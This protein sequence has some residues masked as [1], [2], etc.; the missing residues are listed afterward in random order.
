MG[1]AV[2]SDD[3][4]ASAR[5]GLGD[6]AAPRPLIHLSE[7]SVTVRPGQSTRLR[8]TVVNVGSVVET[9]SLT[10]LGEARAWCTLLP[11]EI[12]LFPGEEGSSTLVVRPPMSSQTIAGTYE[13]GVLATSQVRPSSRAASGA[14]LTV[15]SFISF[16]SQLARSS[17]DMRHST[18]TQLQI[19]N[20]GNVRIDCTV[21]ANDPSGVLRVRC[22]RTEVQLDP[23]ET[24][25][26]KLSISGPLHLFGRFKSRAIR[27]S[28]EVVRDDFTGRQPEGERPSLQVATVTQRPLLSLRL[29]LL[30]RLAVVLGV[31]ALVLTFVITRLL[32]YQTPAVSGAPNTPANFAATIV[33]NN[34][35]ALTWDA[36]SGAS[37]YDIYAVG[38]AGD[39]ASTATPAASPGGTP[40]PTGAAQGPP[41]AGQKATA[42]TPRTGASP[43]G[44]PASSN[45]P[46]VLPSPDDRK[47]ASPV[48]NNCTNVATVTGNTTRHVIQPL[49]ATPVSCY[50]IVA[51]AGNYQSLFSVQQCVNTRAA[52][53]AAASAAAAAAAASSQAATPCSPVKMQA[54]PLSS[55]AIA[56]LWSV[57]KTAPKKDTCSPTAVL[58]G[59]EIQRQILSGW[60]N[61][62]TQPAAADTALEAT[63][64][65]PATNY[66]FR[67]RAMTAT[68]SSEYTRTFCAKTKKAPVLVSPSPSVS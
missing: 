30:G 20:D 58:T 3:F 32:A 39:P 27:T 46:I 28:V 49:P 23:G 52:T 16:R 44:S 66:C 2:S 51:K 65:Q 68:A 42:S 57:P 8:V 56:I 13:I 43:S 21:S 9:Y 19:S 15:T 4:D 34:Q 53:Q 40:V 1:D 17:L 7:D 67:M 10:A 50:R 33:D 54:Q 47:Y 18:S 6:D 64:L 63:A 45:L 31:L 25:W 61:L 48:C 29:G 41:A 22:D 62:P 5:E 12:S 24:T 37:E 59:Y 14:R 35:I 55:T 11:G 38:L 60:T 26:I 36:S